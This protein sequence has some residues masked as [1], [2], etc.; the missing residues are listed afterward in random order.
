MGAVQFRKNHTQLCAELGEQV[1][2]LEHS[3]GGGV[4]VPE[5]NRT[6]QGSFTGM[7]GKGRFTQTEHFREKGEYTK[8]PDGDNTLAMALMSFLALT[9]L[10]YSVRR[11]RVA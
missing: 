7:L 10:H 11:N 8:V 2:L 1:N 5:F 3:D 6:Y 4:V 9:F